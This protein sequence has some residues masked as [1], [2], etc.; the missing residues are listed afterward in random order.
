MNYY[1]LISNYNIHVII[2]FSVCTQT[3]QPLGRDT[4]GFSK[5]KVTWLLVWIAFSGSQPEKVIDDDY[6]KRLIILLNT[7][8]KICSIYV[9][10][11][12]HYINNQKKHYFF[13]NYIVIH[14]PW[15]ATTSTLK[16]RAK[17]SVWY[18]IRGL[19]PKS[20]STCTNIKWLKK[21]THTNVGNN[22]YSAKPL[23]KVIEE[24]TK[25]TIIAI[26]V[27]RQIFE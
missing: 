18:C 14:I 27:H 20:P 8:I 21:S 23:K 15:K 13:I 22:N 5:C 9:Y 2:V 26:P 1:Y 12:L 16:W 10:H 11:I 19:R 4:T 6:Q 25:L 24:L 7:T 3:H 17:E